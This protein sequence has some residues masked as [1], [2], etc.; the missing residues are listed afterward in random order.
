MALD[1]KL[2]SF[3]SL[4]MQVA[5]LWD[6]LPETQTSVP[7]LSDHHINMFST[8]EASYN[9]RDRLRWAV[10][11]KKKAQSLLRNAQ[12]ADSELLVILQVLTARISSMNQRSLLALSTSQSMMHAETRQ[13][14]EEFKAIIL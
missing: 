5:S 9:V 10:L 8:T 11:D 13:V 3:H 2:Q 1:R 4:V 14:L 6:E 7:L 12:E